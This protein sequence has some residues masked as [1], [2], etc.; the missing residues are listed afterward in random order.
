MRKDRLAKLITIVLMATAGVLFVARKS[1]PRQ[2]Q[3]P[4]RTPQD[5]IYAMLDAARLGDSKAYLSQY[6]G[7]MQAGLRRVELEKGAAAFARYLRS[8]TADMKG[9]AVSE[10]TAISDR[11]AQMRVEYVYRDRSEVQVAYLEKVSG[12]WKIDRLDGAEQVKT[13]IPYGTPVQ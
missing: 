1:E 8:S 6:T 7:Q 4:T 12:E 13:I 2:Q 3:Q 9:V 10:L 11:E 5:A